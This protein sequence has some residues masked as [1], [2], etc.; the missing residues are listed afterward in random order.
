MDRPQVTYKFIKEPRTA[1]VIGCPFSGGQPKT[2]VDSGPMKIVADG[3]LEDIKVRSL[4]F[5]FKIDC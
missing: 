1:A 2:G 5:V 3:L 4:T